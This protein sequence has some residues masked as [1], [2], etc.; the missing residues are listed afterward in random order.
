MKAYFCALQL[1]VQA[2]GTEGLYNIMDF[3]GKGFITKDAFATRVSQLR[4]NARS[5]ELAKMRFEISMVMERIRHMQS[6]ILNLLGDKTP[7]K[8]GQDSVIGET[9]QETEI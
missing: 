7:E 2:L 6:R 3:E 8:L 9:G 4:G 1:D 5:L